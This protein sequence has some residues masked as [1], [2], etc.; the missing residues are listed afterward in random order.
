MAELREL[1]RVHA[2]FQ[3]RLDSDIT[4][5]ETRLAS[6]L[7]VS[8]TVAAMCVNEP[9]RTHRFIIGLNRAVE[10]LL[11]RT[12]SRAVTVLYAGCGPWATLALPL[13]ARYPASQL[14]FTLLDIH[15]QS[16]QS[17]QA[18][19]ANLGLADRVAAYV[20]ADA[21][22]YN[23]PQD[24]LPDIIL[25][26]TM[27]VTLRNEPQVAIC[28]NLVTQAPE[29]ILIPEEVRIDLT[30]LD[31]GREHS[32]AE[33]DDQGPPP[34]PER[35]RTHLGRVFTVNREIIAQW[36]DERGDSLPGSRID[37]PEFIEPGLQLSLLTTITT[38]GDLTLRDYESSLTLPT[39]LQTDVPVV[40][41]IPLHFRYRLGSCPGLVAYQDLAPVA[42]PLVRG[43]DRKK[44][45]LE[46]D[47]EKLQEEIGL[48]DEDEWIDHFVKQNYEGC[49][50]AIPLR[51]P[52]GATH[53]IQQIFSNPA[54][55]EFRATD[56][57]RR[58]PYLQQV[59]DRFQ[60]AL[61]SVRLMKLAAG[62]RIKEHV[63]PEL[64]MEQGY[65]R[66]HIPITTNTQMEF[67]L[68]GEAVH[69]A[70]GECWY[71]RLS[72]PH[73]LHNRGSSDRVHIVMDVVAND[74]LRTKLRGEGDVI[75]G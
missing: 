38:Y 34:A 69:M 24:D 17:A 10:D 35:V 51:A 50:Q 53:P 49:W 5:G 55:N 30:L 27:N 14:R 58:A 28:R 2:P 60:C 21:A 8:P 59:L 32:L 39:R 71:L 16:I 70:P 7:A 73:S 68:N 45:P 63:D 66:L 62:S 3:P 47:K 65:A 57:L 26:E 64:A 4:I 40:P 12:P 74:W 1:I 52:A 42:P 11:A 44:L 61:L 37:L 23:I 25:T 54:C 56:F 33:P 19:I 13:M 41:G 18:L 29:A 48:F 72:D 46:F 9:C 31:P 22:E 15:P 67:V 36:Q 43:L 20:V 75:S 6:G